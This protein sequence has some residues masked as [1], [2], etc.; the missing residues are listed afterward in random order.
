M[1]TTLRLP[2]DLL[3]QVKRLAADTDRTM[4]QVIEIALRDLL[5]RRPQREK[6]RRP[7]R[8]PTYGSGG[9]LP[10]VNLDDSAALLEIME[11]ASD[12]ARR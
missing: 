11:G 4:T 1:R 5:A 2:D 9:L 6:G 3:R 12:P 7:V 10:G 8:L